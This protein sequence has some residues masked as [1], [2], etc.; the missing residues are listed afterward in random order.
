MFTMQIRSSINLYFAI[1]LL[2]NAA[3]TIGISY[4]MLFFATFT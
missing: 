3:P 1:F 2:K 4:Y